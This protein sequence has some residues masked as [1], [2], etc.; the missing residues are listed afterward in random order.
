MHGAGPVDGAQGVL[1]DGGI[2]GL[3]DGLLRASAATF[4]PCHRQTA[5]SVT[6]K[7]DKSLAASAAGLSAERI[8]APGWEH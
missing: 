4:V 6:S 8:Q 7:P 3:V 5:A 2:D 1:A